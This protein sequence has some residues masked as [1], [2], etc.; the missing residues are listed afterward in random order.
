MP[1]LDVLKYFTQE[2][3]PQVNPYARKNDDALIWQDEG[4]LSYKSHYRM[5]Y[6]RICSSPPFQRL[7]VKTQVF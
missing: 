6:E 2:A 3:L 4:I 7:R 5:D 1:Y